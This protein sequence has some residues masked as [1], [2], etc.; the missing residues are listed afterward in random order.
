[1]RVVG[2]RH[3]EGRLSFLQA[4]ENRSCMAP[5]TMQDRRPDPRMRIW[6]AD[7][8][9]TGRHELG[10]TAQGVQEC[11][12]HETLC[13]LSRA[14]R[15]APSGP[16]AAAKKNGHRFAAPES[17]YQRRRV[18][19]PGLRPSLQVFVGANRMPGGPPYTNQVLIFT[20][21]LPGCRNFL[22]ADVI[23]AKPCR[24]A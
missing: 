1:L 18:E 15:R 9:G 4:V 6:G 11:K 10:V 19:N 3:I 13:M 17:R 20:D 16:S 5:R 8:E 7:S 14:V 23:L 2:V 12:A 22:R 21:E 24:A